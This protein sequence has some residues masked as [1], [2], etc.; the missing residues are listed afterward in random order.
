MPARDISEEILEYLRKHPEASDTLEGITEWWLLNQRI[1]DEVIKVK[2]AVSS[3]VEG[4]WLVEIKG[5]DSRVR[6]R[7]KREGKHTESNTS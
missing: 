6:Y 5:S 7:Y 3:L 4:G 2:E 1:H